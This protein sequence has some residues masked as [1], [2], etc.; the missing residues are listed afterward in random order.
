MATELATD[1]LINELRRTLD[2]MYADLDRVELLTAAL[3]GFAQPVPD[4]EPSFRHFN[5]V[6]LS[7]YELGSDG[8]RRYNSPSSSRRCRSEASE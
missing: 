3:A 7:A 4:Y 6:P 5:R 8:W 1:L 2:S